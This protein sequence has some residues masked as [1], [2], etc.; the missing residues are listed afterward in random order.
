[1]LAG[2]MPAE[3][4]GRHSNVR[5][6]GQHSCLLNKGLT[7]ATANLNFGC[8]KVRKRKRELLCDDEIQICA[9]DTRGEVT[10]GEV[11][12]WEMVGGKLHH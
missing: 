6:E 9:R 12:N 7:N 1:M 11:G 10:R 5:T 3:E 8:F 4:G 2:N